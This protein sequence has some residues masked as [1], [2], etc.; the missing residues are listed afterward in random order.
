MNDSIKII[1]NGL[2]FTGDVQN[3]AGKLTIIVQNGRIIEIGRR[4]DA[5]KATYQ[6]AEVINA[7][8]K[9]ILPGFVDAHHTGKSFILQF[10]TSGLPMSQWNKSP[11]IS[12]AMRYLREEATYEEFLM[13]EEEMQSLEDLKALRAAKAEE[14]AAPTVPLSQARS[15][16]GL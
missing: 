12:R 1:E 8:G 13:L 4:A 16:L 11:V 7:A 2:V 10:L 5:L 9:I 14:G 15:D 3:R 6:N